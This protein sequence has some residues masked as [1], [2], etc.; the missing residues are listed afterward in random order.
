M[1]LTL[2]TNYIECQFYFCVFTPI[3]RVLL[4]PARYVHMY[5]IH[6]YKCVYFIKDVVEM[7]ERCSITDN[8]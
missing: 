3:A 7:C 6:V 4:S 1:I 5:G 2:L 8:Y